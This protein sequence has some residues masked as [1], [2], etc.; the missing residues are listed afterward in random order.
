MMTIQAKPST[1]LTKEVLKKLGEQGLIP[2]PHESKEQFVKRIDVLKKVKEDPPKFLKG[3]AVSRW[4][5]DFHKE[6]GAIPKWL[7]L[8]YSNHGLPLWQG[9]ALWIFETP[10]RKKIP[11][12]QL[13]EG[14]KKGKFLFYSQSEVLL[15]ETL[16]A[17]R[18]AFNEPRFEEILAY[19]HSKSKWRRFIGPL[20]R[21]PSHAFF[22][23]A[24][25]FISLIVQTTSLFFLTSPLLPYVKFVTLLPIMDLTLRTAALIRD[26]RIVKKALK[27]LSEI[28]PNQKEA[29][30]VLIRLKDSEIQ[31]F[32]TEPIE[33]L[34]D[35]VEEEIPKS[36]RWHQIIAQFC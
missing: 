13:R 20:F 35:Y 17:I 1:N 19:H 9:A 12:I 8:T 26:Q 6:L 25:I 24:L 33:K 15:H 18:V 34:L 36:L 27:R 14:F 10:D 16:H 3:K 32:A 22:F 23:I 2:G 29:F 31:K 28:F 5:P 21:K 11:I 30:S 4:N 7:P